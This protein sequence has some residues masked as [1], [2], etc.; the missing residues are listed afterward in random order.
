[1]MF[2]ETEGSRLLNEILHSGVMEYMIAGGIFMWPIL[3]MGIIATAV[4]IDRYR[5]LRFYRRSRY[6]TP[7]AWQ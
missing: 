4:V 6:W 1:M 7:V 3:V 2:A 5:S